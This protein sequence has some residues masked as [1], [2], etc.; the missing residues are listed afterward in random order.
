MIVS[1]KPP[2]PHHVR[3]FSKWCQ[4][5]TARH[6]PIRCAT[7][8]RCRSGSVMPHVQIATSIAS[9]SVAA[10]GG[11]GRAATQAGPCCPHQSRPP[12]GTFRPHQLGLRGQ[13]RWFSRVADTA[14]GRLTSPAPGCTALKPPCSPCYPR[15]RVRRRAEVTLSTPARHP[16]SSG[17]PRAA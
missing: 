10:L 15:P 13:I 16:V 12:R 5:A 11:R 1:Q 6:E 17:A 4:R 2:C 14:R 9:A 7:R 3:S 8:R